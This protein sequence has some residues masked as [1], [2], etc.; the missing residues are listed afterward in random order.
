MTFRAPNLPGVFTHNADTFVN[1]PLWTLKIEVMFYALVPLLFLTARFIRFERLL[2]VLYV[3]SI[4]WNLAMGHI[5]QTHGGRL[6]EELQ[7]QLPGQLSYF[8]AGALLEHYL[9]WFKRHAV[10]LLIGAVVVLVAGLYIDLFPF[11]PAALGV[12]VIYIAVAFPVTIPAARFGDFSYGLYICHFPIIQ[13]FAALAVLPGSPGLRTI[14]VIGASLGYAVLSWHLVEK[15]F[16]LSWP[17]PAIQ[18]KDAPA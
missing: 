16:L 5:A 6:A 4:A 9:A 3:A 10:K 13:A 12:V 1:G 14:V 11:Y 18:A 8:M 17:R 15:P 7:R 2:V